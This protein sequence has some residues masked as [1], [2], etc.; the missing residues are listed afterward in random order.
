M[1]GNHFNVIGGPLGNLQ[2]SA[3]QQ[4]D[5]TSRHQSG[6]MVSAVSPYW[7][8]G[9]FIYGK[10]NGTIAQFGLA[11]CT[12][13]VASG[14][15]SFLFTAAPNTANLARSVFVAMTDMVSG[16]FG[17]FQMSGMVPVNSAAAV[18]ADTSFGIAAA[19][20]GGAVAAGKQI[21]GARV[22]LA[23]TTTVAKTNCVN[24][25]GSFKLIVPNADG[26]FLGAYLS[27]TGVGA[28]AVVTEISPDGREVTMSVV[29]TAAISGTVT[30]TY[31]NAVVFYNVAHINRPFAQGAIT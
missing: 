3:G 28:A 21:L 10:A 7:G 8:G 15:V 1:S 5:T 17:W 13:A 14:A 25:A 20:Q 2:I 19:G 22:I 27:G 31:N 30:A 16:E 26:W 23:S 9:E 24:N 12:P 29:S 11:V 4:P 6:L 18:A